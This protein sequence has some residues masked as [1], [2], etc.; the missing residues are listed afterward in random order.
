MTLD[1][2]PPIEYADEKIQKNPI[3]DATKGGSRIELEMTT[4]VVLC[5]EVLT[6]MN[7]REDPQV[8][9]N[10]AEVMIVPL[11]HTIPT[12]L[13]GL[14]FHILAEIFKAENADQEYCAECYPDKAYNVYAFEDLLK[15]AVRI[16]MKPARKKHSKRATDPY[17]V[18]HYE[19]YIRK[20]I[21]MA[22]SQITNF[23][24]K[25]I[26]AVTRRGFELK[27]L[28]FILAFAMTFL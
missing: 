9:M 20:R 24:P 2:L 3:I 8:H 11:T 26:H 10:T 23:F 27:V 22:F 4:M 15:E 7:I 1:R 17:V 21:E 6:A 28:F 14:L 16:V 25:H 19:Q 18:V 13:W 5:D 12:H